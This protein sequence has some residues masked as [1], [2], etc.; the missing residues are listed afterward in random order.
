MDNKIE[1]NTNKIE[2]VEKPFVS[3]DDKDIIDSWYKRAREVTPETFGDFIN[4]L[5]HGYDLDYGAKIH[6]AAA[7]TIAMFIACDD[8]FSFSGFQSS[9]SIMQVLYKLNYPYNKTGIRVIDYDN[10]LY[11]QYEDTFR[12][13]PRKTWKLIRKRADE[14]IEENRSTAD[15]SVLHHWMNISFGGVPFE[16]YISD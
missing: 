3:E 4:E 12:S 2:K 13:I 5:L 7:C 14:L 9:A 16:Y 8:I 11:P 10:M 15:P 1:I 6:A